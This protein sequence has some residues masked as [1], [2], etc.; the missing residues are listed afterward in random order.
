LLDITSFKS[1]VIRRLSRELEVMAFEISAERVELVSFTDIVD[2]VYKL[3]LL[4][5]VL[6]SETIHSICCLKLLFASTIALLNFSVFCF[7]MESI[8]STFS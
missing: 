7:V 6:S 5:S 8:F 2:S 3:I 4:L 1:S